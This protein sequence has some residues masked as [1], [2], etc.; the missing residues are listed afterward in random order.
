MFIP[1]IRDSSI[2]D[3]Q[4]VR[5]SDEAYVAEQLAAE[6]TKILLLA[7]DKPVVKS[8]ADRSNA[9]IK[10][11]SRAELQDLGL[12]VG[13]SYFL[14]LHPDG[15]ARFALALTEHRARATPDAFE[16]MQP[17]VDLRTL[18]MKSDMDP[19]EVSMI[20]MAKSL[21]HWHENARHCGRCG[22]ATDVKDAGWR[23]KCWACGRDQFP[24]TDPVVIMLIVDPPND[25]CLL[26]HEARFE[27]MMWSTLAGFLEPGE[28]VRHAVRRETMEE[29][30][31][32]VGE[33]RFHLT[34]PWPFPHSLMI[35]CH[36]IAE[37]TDIQIDPNEI[38]EARWFSREEVKLMFEEAHPEGI[39]IPG[40][41]A[42]ARSL[43]QA[44]VD[45]EVK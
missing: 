3:R 36:G 1:T 33:V 34:Q 37:T 28:D 8:D 17:M 21:N 16:A 12:P 30:G 9:A 24:R 45:G 14:G 29:A 7:G 31:I 15:T 42:I 11:F 13:E 44:F 43:I 2:L 25:R 10:W 26:G 22:G 20:G 39:T 18:A 5:R 40:K 41:Q 4:S 38:Q 6:G 27:T 35:G 19:E 23:R 32:V